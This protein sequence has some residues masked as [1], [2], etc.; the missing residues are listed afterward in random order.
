MVHILFPLLRNAVMDS[1]LRS[2][3]QART[4]VAEAAVAQGV[5]EQTDRQI[6]V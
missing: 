1:D 6:A 5:V 4:L 3:Q 2:I